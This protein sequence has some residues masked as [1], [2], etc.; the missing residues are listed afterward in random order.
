MSYKEVFQIPYE[1]T[2]F[3]GVLKSI[4]LLQYFQKMAMYHSYQLGYTPAILKERQ[5]GWMLHK[6][7]VRPHQLPKYN[8]EIEIKTWSN[9]VKGFKGF[10]QFEVY[11]LGKRIIDADSLWLFLDMSKRRVKRVPQSIIDD[12]REPGLVVSVLPVEKWGVPTLEN[13]VFENSITVRRSDID[14]HFHVNNAVYADYV[15]S[16]V[17]QYYKNFTGFG[18]FAIQFNKEIQLSVGSVIVRLYEINDK[19]YF[20]ISQNDTEFAVGEYEIIVDFDVI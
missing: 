16:T 15:E 19:K 3:N 8:D 1:D 13:A 20:S 7:H 9:S 17:C 4:S 6:V 14:T 5:I 2:D 12:Y 10:R 18:L 11:H